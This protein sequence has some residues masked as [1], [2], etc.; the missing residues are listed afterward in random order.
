MVPIEDIYERYLTCSGIITDTRKAEENQMFFALKGD[1][2]NG[3][4]YA[5]EALSKGCAW[6]VVDE[7]KYCKDDR[8]LLV[9]DV[10]QALQSL[11]NYHR[12]KLDIPV[13]AITGTNGKT[14]TKE[15]VDRVLQ[16]KYVTHATKGNLNNHI[17]VPITL[18][19]MTK[20][21]EIAIVEMGANHIG[22][23]E[24]LCNIALPNYGIITNIGKAHLEGFGSLEGVVKAKTELY[25]HIESKGDFLFVNSGNQLLMELSGE[26][27][28]KTYGSTSSAHIK[29]RLVSEFPTLI[30]EF[31][32]S[33]NSSPIECKTKII[34]AHNF[35]NIMAA[36]AVGFEFGV[37]SKD[38][39]IAVGMYESENNRSQLIQTEHN[40]IVL[41]AYNANPMNMKASIE[42][43]AKMHG[44]NKLVILGDM[45]EL[46]QY[47]E[48]EHRLILEHLKENQL[49]NVMLVGDHFSAIKEYVE[50]THFKNASEAASWIQLNPI[51]DTLVL[52]KGSRGVGLEVLVAKM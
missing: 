42:S 40:K 6:V 45:L 10:L 34:G 3:N 46:G 28:K 37:V 41:D 8:F 38:I 12:N 11:A 23:I 18:L 9:K 26:C 51:K 19:G 35:E 32:D 7:K 43:F 21:T 15:L 36:I 49:S 47:A 48:E 5:L 50:C 27:K 39:S 22:E 52:I 24:S 30:F 14:T 20:N 2:F 4:E 44:K 13:I 1:N 33:K 29:G 17:G 25:K 16:K 31:S